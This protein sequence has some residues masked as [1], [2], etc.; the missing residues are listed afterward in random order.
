[1][2]PHIVHYAATH[3][4]IKG[5]VLSIYIELWRWLDLMEYRKVSAWFIG[6]RLGIDRRTVN[7]ALDVLE[8]VGLLQRDPSLGDRPRELRYRMVLSAPEPPPML[9]SDAEGEAATPTPPWRRKPG[10]L[11]V[12][13]ADEDA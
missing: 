13:Q 4:D 10:A 5:R 9:R 7:R 12:A 2:I 1:M 8:D 3:P 11:V 6:Q